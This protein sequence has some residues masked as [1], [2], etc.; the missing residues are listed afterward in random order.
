VQTTNQ[1]Q[2][3][4]VVTNIVGAVTSTPATLTVLGYCAS[5]QAAQTRYPAGTTIPLTVQTFNCAPRAPVGNSAAVLWIY[6]AGTSRTI[7]LTTGGSGS[8]TVNFTP[9][10][11]EAGLAQY[12]AA[13]PGVN[14]PPRKA[15]S[16]SWAWG[17]A[18]PASRP[19]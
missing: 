17:W 2:Y 12:A 10:A 18:R 16:H 5:A 13:L 4:V 6:N 7:P 11:G 3:T 14:N 8:A 1:G 9:L 15:R 19:C